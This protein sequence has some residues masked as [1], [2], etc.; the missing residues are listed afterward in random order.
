[1]CTP[2]SDI[3]INAI[4]TLLSFLIYK[5]KSQ[6]GKTGQQLGVLGALACTGLEFGSEHPHGIIQPSLTLNFGESYGLLRQQACMWHT[7]IHNINS[8][9]K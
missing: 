8:I 2:E 7:Y 1:M 5:D 4:Q 3:A 6:L 9:N